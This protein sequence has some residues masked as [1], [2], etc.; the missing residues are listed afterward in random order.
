[1]HRT[2]N[3][4]IEKGMVRPSLDSPTIYT[5]VDLDTALK[6]ALRKRESELREMEASK[7]ELQELSKQQPF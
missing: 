4:L 7:R 6:S 2:L 1:V 3:N 5:A